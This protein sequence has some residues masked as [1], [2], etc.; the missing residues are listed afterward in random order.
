M[1]YKPLD[2]YV[3]PWGKHKGKRLDEVPKGYLRWCL[4][5]LAVS[6]PLEE[7]IRCVLEHRLPPPTT[8][9][10]IRQAMIRRENDLPQ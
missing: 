5:E 2:F 3:M 8:D 9:E 6:V 4:K 7:A 1:E 10:L